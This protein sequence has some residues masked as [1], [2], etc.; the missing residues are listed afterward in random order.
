MS[1]SAEVVST[2]FFYALGYNVPENYLTFVDRSKLTISPNAMMIV[3]KTRMRRMK[4]KDVDLIYKRIA[5]LPDGRVQAV[6]SRVVPGDILGTF[7]FNGTRTDDPNDI[8]PH[9]D[10]RELRGLR[11]FAA[12]LN[13][14]ELQTFNT[15]DTNLEQGGSQC[16]KH[17]L[18]D[19]NS[20]F[21][22]ANIRPQNPRSGNEYYFE[23][24]PVLKSAYTFGL[25]DRKW[26]HVKYPKYRSIGRFESS[27]FQPQDWKPDY[28]NAALNKMQNEDAFW[29]TK[30]VMQ[31]DDEKI[32]ALVRTGQYVDKEAEE[33]LIQTLIR[34][35]DKIIRYYFAQINPLDSFA[36]SDKQELTF[37]N[38]GVE[39][40]LASTASYQYQWFRFD[41]EQRTSEPLA[42]SG[43]AD[44]PSISIPADDSAYLLVRIQ[45]KSEGQ[46]KWQKNLDVYIRNTATKSVVGIEREN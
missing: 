12:W 20:T 27:Y 5:A 21:G 13:H 39:A 24:G 10:R 46:P 35:R 1:T 45:T 16:I 28:P 33:Y 7:L 42:A 25:W 37:R 26:R 15:L 38:L 19:F 41:N 34:R 4:K 2:K 43:V 9:E 11:V 8:F 44:T 30:I 3:D 6:A 17:Y 40:G 14:D 29:A 22:S 18:I 31:F 23:S 36:V 32:R